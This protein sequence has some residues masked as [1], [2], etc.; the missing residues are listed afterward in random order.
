MTYQVN[1]SLKSP[2]RIFYLG[3]MCGLVI[4]ETDYKTRAW[5]VLNFVAVSKSFSSL[6][7]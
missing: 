3:R 1:K 7:A 6:L 4:K 5:F 2:D